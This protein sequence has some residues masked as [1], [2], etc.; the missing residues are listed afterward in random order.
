MPL[1]IYHFFTLSFQLQPF[2]KRNVFSFCLN[3]LSIILQVLF[4]LFECFNINPLPVEKAA[5]SS[6]LTLRNKTNARRL[7]FHRGHSQVACQR[8]R[9]SLHNNKP[10]GPKLGSEW[11]KP[12]PQTA[13]YNHYK[14]Q[15]IKFKSC[16]HSR[17]DTWEMQ[18]KAV[19]NNSWAIQTYFQ[20]CYTLKLLNK[21]AFYY[22]HFV[23]FK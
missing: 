1:I 15:T 9:C 7:Q 2:Y 6:K 4:S 14:R 20:L 8:D 23:I 12:D 22:T 10:A 16:C 21:I 19:W 18:L 13:S 3:E 5:G 17:E 11:S